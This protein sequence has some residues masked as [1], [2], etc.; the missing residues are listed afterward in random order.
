MRTN[1]SWSLQI[2]NE[3]W[4]DMTRLTA[5]IRVTGGAPPGTALVEAEGDDRLLARLDLRHAV[6]AQVELDYGPGQF[7]IMVGTTSYLCGGDL[8]VSGGRGGG[9][10]SGIKARN[11][12]IS[13]VV[14]DGRSV[15]S[16]IGDADT[17]F[18]VDD[19][20]I[21]AITI[22][23]DTKLHLTAGGAGDLFVGG[24]E[25]RLRA[26]LSGSFDTILQGAV[27]PDLRLSGTG[28]LEAAVRGSLKLDK[29]GTG[30]CRLAVEP[31]G[32]ALP[33][34]DIRVSGTGRVRVAGERFGNA[35]LDLSG[36]ASIAIEGACTDVDAAMSGVG[37]IDIREVVGKFVK[38]VTGVGDVNVG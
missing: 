1:R 36:A 11:V 28:R 10:L 12:T 32:D 25:G 4:L 34:L 17:T 20:P 19:L 21:V 8:V 15:V 24:L 37:D 38:R 30:N 31:H 35:K 14:I 23:A 7:C 5:N 6:P 29:S 18:D 16:A 9:V 26:A 13:N 22:P 2:P 33:D 27:S 3:L